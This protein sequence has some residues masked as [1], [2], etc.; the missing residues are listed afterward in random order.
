[1]AGNTH[2]LDESHNTTTKATVS[3]PILTEIFEQ[4]PVRSNGI[5]TEPAPNNF[6]RGACHSVIY[7]QKWWLTKAI[8][9]NPYHQDD[10][11]ELFP[12]HGPNLDLFQ[13]QER[14]DI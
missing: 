14:K 12:S 6:Q 7:D 8:M 13:K 1:M 2:H 5:M 9:F 10:Q 11:T 3:L 4:D